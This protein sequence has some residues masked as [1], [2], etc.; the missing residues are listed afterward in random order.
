MD[1]LG[2][3]EGP[4]EVDK[5]WLRIAPTFRSGSKISEILKDLRVLV[6][7]MARVLLK[8]N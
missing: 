4:G 5:L 6:E 2:D 8:L 7:T 3:W 1:M